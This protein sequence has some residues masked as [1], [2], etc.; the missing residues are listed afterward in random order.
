MGDQ[1]EVAQRRWQLENEILGADAAEI[2]ELYRW[3]AEEQRQIQQ[4][5]PWTSDPNYFKR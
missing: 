5:R 4:Q 3:D 2:S 1:T